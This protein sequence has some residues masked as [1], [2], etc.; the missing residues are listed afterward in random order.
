MSLRCSR[1][2]FIYIFGSSCPAPKMISYTM[3]HG[4]I[5]YMQL[6]NA[7]FIYFKMCSICKFFTIIVENIYIRFQSLVTVIKK[8]TALFIVSKHFLKKMN[9]V[10]HL[11]KFVNYQN[12][13][14]KMVNFC[15]VK[16]N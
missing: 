6:N 10:C 9:E 13:C 7:M 14:L 12:S 11:Q 4:E 1:G 15:C 16:L 2:F 5:L 3:R 8:N